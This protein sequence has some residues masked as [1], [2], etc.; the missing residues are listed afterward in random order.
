MNESKCIGDVKQLVSCNFFTVWHGKVNGQLEINQ[1][2]PFLLCSVI[3]GSCS[4]DNHTFAKDNHFILPNNY[5]KAV[6][7]GNAEMIFSS[8]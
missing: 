1:N 6:F 4:L 3:E 7:K 2:Q 8:I 5:G